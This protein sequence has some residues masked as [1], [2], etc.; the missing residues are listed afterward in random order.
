MEGQNT[1]SKLTRT[2]SSLLRSPTLRSSVHSLSALEEINS[3]PEE[4]K[5]HLPP[6]SSAAASSLAGY[7]GHRLA[8]LSLLLLL[9]LVFSYFFLRYQSPSLWFLSIASPAVVA[10]LKRSRLSLFRRRET[11]RWFIGDEEGDVENPSPKKEGKAVREGIEVYSNGDFYEGEFHR[12]KCNGNGVYNFF[13][14]G[15]YEGDWVNG[16]YD[17]YGIERWAKGSRYS[18]QYRHGLRHG[19]GVYRFY[20]GDSYAGEWVAGQSNGRGVQRCSDGSF[21]VGEFKC[22]VKHGVGF[23]HFRN[24]D[25]YMGEYFGDKIHGF[26]V[27][28]FAN[29]QCYE[30]SWHEGRRQGFGTYTFRRGEARSGEWNCGALKSPLPFADTNVQRAVQSAR[31]ASEKAII[32]PRVEEQVNKAVAMANRAATAARVAAIKAVENQMNGKFCNTET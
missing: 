1:K 10:A 25:K 4:A 31:E 16:L 3:D 21:Y 23:Y 30:G 26:G 15:R 17:G 32:L 24:G 27:Y 28:H 9:I 7:S 19:F 8:I 5:P 29:G 18:G 13:G 11:V 6:V 14:H 12:G 22:G 20:N 2:P